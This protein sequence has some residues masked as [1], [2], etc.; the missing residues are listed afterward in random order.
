MALKERRFG[1]MGAYDL[2]R[3]NLTKS[4]ATTMCSNIKARNPDHS[5]RIFKEP[6]GK[7]SVYRRGWV[8]TS[9]KKLD[10]AYAANRASVERSNR[11]F[12]KDLPGWAD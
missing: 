2:V 11:N 1:G 10:A 6:N 5:T 8:S 9:K 3:T 12:R 4:E 7:Y